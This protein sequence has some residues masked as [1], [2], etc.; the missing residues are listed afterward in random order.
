MQLLHFI[1]QCCACTSVTAHNSSLFKPI[2]TFFFF[3][4][5]GNGNTNLFHKRAKEEVKNGKNFMK[6]ADT[7]P[8]TSQTAEKQKQVKA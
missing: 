3:F 4:Y 1:Y 5:F 8:I 2:H 7:R 6:A